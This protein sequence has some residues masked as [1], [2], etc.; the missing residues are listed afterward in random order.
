MRGGR[1]HVENT[2]LLLGCS[3]QTQSVEDTGR[4]SAIFIQTVQPTT[5]TN[6]VF[7]SPVLYSKVNETVSDATALSQTFML[8]EKNFPKSFWRR[9]LHSHAAQGKMV[10]D[11]LEMTPRGKSFQAVI[12]EGLFDFG[13]FPPDHV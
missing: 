10:K 2:A 12:P 4:V 1:K 11:A 8:N 6:T 13:L 5:T 7:N 3:R 9:R